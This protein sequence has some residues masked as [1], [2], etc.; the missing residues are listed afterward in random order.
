M[1][2]K[3]IYTEE[4][5]VRT[6]PDEKARIDELAKAGNVSRSR[7]LIVS[8]LSGGM[9]LTAELLPQIELMLE[10]H[11]IALMDLRRVRNRLNQIADMLQQRPESLSSAELAEAIK[12]VTATILFLRSQWDKK[13]SQL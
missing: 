12:E 6:T 5:P 13:P 3:K 8:A 7:L 10:L 9:P 1:A 4:F 11:G 2:R